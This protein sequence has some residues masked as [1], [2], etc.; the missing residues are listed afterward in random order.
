MIVYDDIAWFLGSTGQLLQESLMCL[1]WEMA[2]GIREASSL[3]RLT[4]GAG[5]G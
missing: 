3:T 4:L 5:F 1:G 2:R